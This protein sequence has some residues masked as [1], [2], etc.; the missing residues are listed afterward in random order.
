MRPIVAIAFALAGVMSGSLNAA[1]WDPDDRWDDGWSWYDPEPTYERAPEPE[2]TYERAPEPEPTYERAPGPEPAVIDRWEP[3]ARSWAPPEPA[4]E[5]RELAAEA[6]LHEVTEVRAADR[7]IVETDRTVYMTEVEREDAG[8]F[9]RQVASVETGESSAYDRL[10]ANQRMAMSDGRRVAGDYYETYVWDAATRGFVLSSVD[11]FA[12]DLEL[13]RLAAA[14]PSPAASAVLVPIAPMAPIA[15]DAP[16]GPALAPAGVI[17]LFT[18]RDDNRDVTA[19]ALPAPDRGPGAPTAPRGA[20]DV[21]VGVALDPQG[22]VLS[23]FTI[24]RGRRI[25]LWVRAFVDG[26]PARVV[27]WRLVSGDVTALGPIGGSGDEPFVGQWLALPHV[28]S[29][30]LLRFE[31]VVDVAGEANRTLDAGIEVSVRSPG[32]VE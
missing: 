32:I 31:A 16:P 27:G 25:P 8:T 29:A 1:G 9:A 19:P 4:V 10:S 3:E 26:S 2:P 12:D 22:D 7:V 13:K 18:A 28:G 24:L 5:V 23:R 20:R 30:Y 6:G 11:F 21:R 17:D 14:G 15:I